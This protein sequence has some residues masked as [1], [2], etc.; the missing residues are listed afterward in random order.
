MTRFFKSTDL[1]IFGGLAVLALAVRGPALADQVRA[2]FTSD[3]SVT[4]VEATPATG[5]VER[6]Q[7]SNAGS[8]DST[9]PDFG[10]AFES[11]PL[12]FRA[13]RFPGCATHRCGH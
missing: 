7:P 12:R 1:L 2:A 8:V 10:K 11:S 3:A 13:D 4:A 6:S 9:Q 5:Q